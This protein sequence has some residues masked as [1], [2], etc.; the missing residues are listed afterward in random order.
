M[1][2]I[3]VGVSG[4]IDSLSA[5]LSFRD[6]DIDVIPIFLILSEAQMKI[7]DRVKILYKS[8]DMN[9]VIKDERD[10]FQKNIIDY[11]IFTYKEGMTPNPCAMC[12]RKI[13]FPLLQKYSKELKCGGFS[14]GHYIR[15]E[16]EKIH[17]GKDIDKDQSYFV[18][19]VARKN[20]K[21]FI[22]S[23][24]S[25]IKKKDLYES[26]KSRTDISLVQKESQ[27]ICFIEN[28][29]YIDFLNKRAGIKE[30]R[31]DFIDDEGKKIGEHRGYF[32]YTIGKRR[33]LEMGFNKRMYVKSINS[34][35]N[36]VHLTEKKN[37]FS[38][39]FLIKPI[40]IFEDIDKEE[41]SIKTRYRQ[42]ETKC[43]IHLRKDNLIKINLKEKI[44]AVTPGQISVIY[45]GDTVA[46]SGF[47][48]RVIW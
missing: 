35:N 4:G 14:T 16:N 31:G 25:E 28:N 48:T 15:I 39:N 21:G 40:E 17:K 30:K 47:I 23:T 37:I 34:E 42:K 20:L 41:Y 26:I 46:A 24:L 12:N 1:K 19:T 36:T 44:E 43:R 9:I 45:N 29:D 11:F 8:I 10:R 3:L 2:R 38:S 5:V 22:N 33:N 7:I 6:N 27:E 32:K 18:A 13:K